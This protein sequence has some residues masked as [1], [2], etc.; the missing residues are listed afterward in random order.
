[1]AACKSMTQN[2]LLDAIAKKT[3]STKKA[4]KDFLLWVTTSTDYQ[5]QVAPGYPAYAAAAKQWLANQ[6]ASHY[7]A[8]DIAGTL[9][10]AAGQVWPGW[11]YGQ[12]SQEA[13]W[14]ATIT[15]GLNAG[16]TIES[17]LPDWQKAVVNYA[18]SNG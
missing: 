6:A 7:Y 1:M 2:Q 16:K 11:G 9:Q 12:F 14:A 3:N 8:N 4:A 18:K 10:A 17:M 5:G 15:P 13:V